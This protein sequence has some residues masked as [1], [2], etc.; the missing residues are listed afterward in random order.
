[1]APPNKALL[2]TLAASFLALCCEFTAP[3]EG[4]V[5]HAVKDTGGIWSICRGHTYNVHEGDT[6]TDDQCKIWYKQ[7][8]THAI[9]LVDLFTDN[10][11]IPPNAK[12]VFVD[13]VFN[14]GG[15]DFKGST[16]VKMIKAGNY[17]GACRQ[18]PRWH[19]AGHKD[20]YIRANACYGI[21]TRRQR[22]M[23]TCLKGL[24]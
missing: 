23:E 16:M 22:Q 9:Y 24:K 8:M 11:P 6:A 13:E 19:Y 5:N 10:A 4:I 21:I 7:D 1:M 17:A 14:T 18:F 15:G 12:K 2:G 3:N 20:C